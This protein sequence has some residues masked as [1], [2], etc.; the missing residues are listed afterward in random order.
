VVLQLK[1][2][3]FAIHT[4]Y[5]A[6]L[7]LSVGPKNSAGVSS[8]VAVEAAGEVRASP[9]IALI[10]AFELHFPHRR[11]SFYGL[12]VVLCLQ[13]HNCGSC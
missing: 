7:A 9:A 1:K 2:P 4:I 13:D 3:I 5:L 12:F 10:A 8:L 6:T 11:D